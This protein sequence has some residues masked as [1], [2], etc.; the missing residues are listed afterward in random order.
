MAAREA[1][2]RAQVREVQVHVHADDEQAACQ[3]EPRSEERESQKAH[4]QQQ[5]RHLLRGAERHVALHQNAQRQVQPGAARDGRRDGQRVHGVQ[6]RA[7]QVQ[8]DAEQRAEHG[9][10]ES[11]KR[12]QAR[13]LERRVGLLL[14]AHDVGAHIVEHGQRCQ[15]QQHERNV[16]VGRQQLAGEEVDHGPRQGACRQV[17]PHVLLPT[18]HEHLGPK[19]EDEREA[20]PAQEPGGEE[21]SRGNGR[22]MGDEVEQSKRKG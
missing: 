13:L 15:R 18:H 5:K 16:T 11:G 2:E 19:K 17:R 1:H 4:H 12:E 10:G 6:V 8:R 14:A 20:A 21:R 9:H 22:V 7:Q 3:H